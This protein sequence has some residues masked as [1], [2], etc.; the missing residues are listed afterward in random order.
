M[1]QNINSN[2]I[3]QTLSV[4]T[5]SPEGIF[6]YSSVLMP[7]FETENGYEFL[8]CKRSMAL[9]HQPGD[10][11]FP[12]GRREGE[13]TPLETALRETRE[14]IGISEE[15]IEILGET[16][17]VITTYGAVIT[18]F[19]ALIKEM[20]PSD[21]KF[22]PD[23]VEE[24]FTVPV[25]FFMETEPEQHFV[26]IKFDIPEDF[27]FEHIVGGKNYPWSKGKQPEL[28]YFYNGNVIWGFTARIVKN[29]CSIIKGEL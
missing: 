6:R 20:S 24:T 10:I 11:C 27:P 18:P 7:L 15:N 4:H 21:I 29:F 26:S 19:V 2:I 23:E 3:Q 17:F 5:P 28:F 22:N 8:F 13:E 25:S 12:G 9:R 1:P 16:D 14:E